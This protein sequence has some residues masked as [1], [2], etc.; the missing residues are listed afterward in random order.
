MLEKF[1]GIDQ[2]VEDMRDADVAKSLGMMC[3]A[4]NVDSIDDF[5]VLDLGEDHRLNDMVLPEGMKF[6]R[7]MGTT[8]LKEG[9][10]RMDAPVMRGVIEGRPFVAVQS[11]DGEVQ[12]FVEGTQP[13]YAN[14][15]SIGDTIVD[16]HP[17]R[18]LLQRMGGSPLAYLQLCELIQEHG[19]V[20]RSTWA[21]LSSYHV[22]AGQETPIKSAR[23]Q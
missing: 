3:A 11:S 18:Y 9:E 10:V 17:D 2:F 7:P 8:D 13:E 22:L 19:T 14:W 21:G 6:I 1:D 15:Y 23:K 4:L 5:A 12:L 16:T 20:H